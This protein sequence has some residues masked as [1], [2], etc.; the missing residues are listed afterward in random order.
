MSILP[1]A[2]PSTDVRLPD[3]PVHRSI[4]AVDVEGSTKRTNPAKGELRRILYELAGAGAASGRDTA[5]STWSSSPIAAT[6]C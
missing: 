6:A 5:P 1:A 4:V 2:M 3:G